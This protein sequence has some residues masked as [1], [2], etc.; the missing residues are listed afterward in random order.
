MPPHWT[1]SQ[2]LQGFSDFIRRITGNNDT[3]ESKSRNVCFLRCTD[4]S[5]M[6][7]LVVVSARSLASQMVRQV[8][9]LC[10]LLPPSLSLINCISSEESN[11]LHLVNS[12]CTK[13][14]ICSKQH[15]NSQR[16]DAN[17]TNNYRIYAIVYLP[18]AKGFFSLIQ[19]ITPYYL[20]FYQTC[21]RHIYLYVCRL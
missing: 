4:R 19:L 8:T 21:F 17:G 20:L 3:V 11:P 16:D 15:F 2:N 10:P 18:K 5:F 13:R 7:T 9:G 1:F 6:Q 14:R 12:A